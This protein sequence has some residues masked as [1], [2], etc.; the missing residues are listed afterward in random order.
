MDK[1]Y[2]GILYGSYT[3]GASSFS[4]GNPA[5]YDK[6]MTTAFDHG[7]FNANNGMQ[8]TKHLYPLIKE[9]FGSIGYTVGYQDQA[10]FWELKDAVAKDYYVVV[11]IRFI[12]NGTQY[13]L[14]SVTTQR[15]GGAHFARVIG[16]DTEKELIYLED[17]LN[18]YGQSGLHTWTVSFDQ[19]EIIWTSPETMVDPGNIGT[20]DFAPEPVDRIFLY[21]IKPPND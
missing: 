7:W 21:Y 14:D 5:T 20:G 11:D 8:P 10:Y 4:G 18:Q 15:G 19:F 9:V 12:R 16:Y 1:E 2:K 17:N 6:L 13:D 3:C